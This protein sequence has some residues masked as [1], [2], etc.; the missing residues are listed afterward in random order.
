M[1]T[2]Q[3]VL[4]KGHGLFA[5]GTNVKDT[6]QALEE[7]RV[8]RMNFSERKQKFLELFRYS[9]EYPAKEFFIWHGLLTGSCEAGRL[10]FIKDHGFDLEK[11]M[12]TVGEFFDLVKGEY[13]WDIIKDVRK[14]YNEK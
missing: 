4:V 7:K 9:E 12:M 1:H 6:F 3:M 8:A 10:R 14:K 2:T 11:D 13:G 5:H